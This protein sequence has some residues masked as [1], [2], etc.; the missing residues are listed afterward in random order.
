MLQSSSLQNKRVSSDLCHLG[1]NSVS[2]FDECNGVI[3]IF[4]VISSVA[5]VHAGTPVVQKVSQIA[6]VCKE[7]CNLLTCLVSI[8]SI[9]GLTYDEFFVFEFDVVEKVVVRLDERKETT[10]SHDKAVNVKF[11]KW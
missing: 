3:V 4:S 9:L 6:P 1:L 10:N 5:A 7:K 8:L 2:L 11:A